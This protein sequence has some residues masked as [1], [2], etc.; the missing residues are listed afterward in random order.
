MPSPRLVELPVPVAQRA[1]LV[2]QRHG[3]L[4]QVDRAAAGRSRAAGSWPAG[5]GRRRAGSS[6]PPRRPAARGCAPRRRGRRRRSARGGRAARSTASA[7][8]ARRR[9]GTGAA[10]RTPSS[11][12]SSIS[13]NVRVSAVMSSLPRL[14]D[15]ARRSVVVMSLAVSRTVRSGAR[16][17]PDCSAASSVMM[18]SESTATIA[19]VRSVL[20]ELGVLVVEEVDDHQRPVGGLAAHGNRGDPDLAVRRVVDLDACRPRPAA[21]RRRPGTRGPRGSPRRTGWGCGCAAGRP[22]SAT[23]ISSSSGTLRAR[24]SA[25]VAARRRSAP[26][27]GVHALALEQ[28]ELVDLLV[29]LLADARLDARGLEVVDEHAGPGHGDQGEQRDDDG[30]PGPDGDLGEASRRGSSTIRSS[31]PA[32]VV[33]GQPPSSP[34]GSGSS[35]PVLP[36]SSPTRVGEGLTTR[37]SPSSSPPSSSPSSLPSSSRGRPPARVPATAWA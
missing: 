5:S 30:E 13:L 19:Y 12:R 31:P 27:L 10:S 23:S 16:S 25:P 35:S 29:D 22:R 3:Q 37:T 4:A 2:D 20:L 32:G 26:G 28:A 14:G 1:G 17:R 24:K 6:G 9:R 15:A 34:S 7:A 21:T 8:R 18:P 11:S 36:S 33:I